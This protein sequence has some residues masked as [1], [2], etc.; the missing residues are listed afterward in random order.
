MSKVKGIFSGQA[1]TNSSIVNKY[2]NQMM[3]GTFKAS[4]GAAGFIHE[5]KFIL[6]EGN[7]RMSAALKYALETGDMKFVNAILEKGRFI[8]ANPIDYGYNIFKFGL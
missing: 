2:F 7:H 6:T 3:E 8:N 1:G 4:E 5:G